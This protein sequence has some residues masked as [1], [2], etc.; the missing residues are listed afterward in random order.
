MW[1]KHGDLNFDFETDPSKVHVQ[2]VKMQRLNSASNGYVAD[3]FISCLC[4]QQVDTDT[5]K[6]TA[7]FQNQ[8]QR[9]RNCTNGTTILDYELNAVETLGSA[10][11]GIDTSK[12]VANYKSVDPFVNIDDGDQKK[13]EKYIN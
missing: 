3:T 5:S 1:L 8:K 2:C 7:V 13:W 10:K 6:S 12:T 4:M 11:Q 9:W